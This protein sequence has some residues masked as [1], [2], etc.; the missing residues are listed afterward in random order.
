MNRFYMICVALASMYWISTV[1]PKMYTYYASLAAALARLADWKSNLLAGFTRLPM[2]LIHIG[3]W[4]VKR[5]HTIRWLLNVTDWKNRLY[6]FLDPS[7]Q[8]LTRCISRTSGVRTLVISTLVTYTKCGLT[9]LHL[10]K[11]N[12]PSSLLDAITSATIAFRNA[13]VMILEF[14]SSII[15]FTT[16]HLMRL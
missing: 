13:I 1:T 11:S 8:I 16:S 14:I 4:V 3:E 6:A 12:M 10:M 2:F 5:I 9:Y 15:A 7:W